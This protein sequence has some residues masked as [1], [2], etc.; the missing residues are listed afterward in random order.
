[1]IVMARDLGLNYSF[2][3]LDTKEVDVIDRW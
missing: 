2:M 3:I 1:M